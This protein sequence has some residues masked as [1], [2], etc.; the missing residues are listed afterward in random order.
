MSS[1][2]AD[3][4]DGRSSRRR[5]LWGFGA[6]VAL[7]LLLVASVIQSFASTHARR[8]S[9]EVHTHTLEVLLVAEQLRSTVGEAIHGQRGYVFTGQAELLRTYDQAIADASR[10]TRQLREMTVDNP[11][12][13]AR[14][15]AMAGQLSH[16]QSVLASAVQLVRQGNQ[17][18]ALA[19]VRQGLD[20]RAMV[21][22]VA[23]ID[24]MKAEERRLLAARTVASDRAEFAARAADLGIA[25]LALIF[26]LI[27]GWAGLTASRARTRTLE[28]EEKLRRA[29]TTDF[30]TGL[31]NR[32]AFMAALDTEIGR[33]K[34]S[35]Q[36]L[37][38]ALID[39]DNFKKVNDRFGHQGGDDVLRK[40]AEVVRHHMRDSDIVGRIGGEEFGVLMP[41]TDQIQSGI[42]ADRLRDAVARRHFVTG[43]GAL[44]P[45][46]I[47]VGVAHLR[48][49]EGRDNWMGRAD[50]ALYDAK[51][52]GR[53]RTRTAA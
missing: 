3:T 24:L 42:A 22:L 35:G 28:M 12:Q 7:T 2:P 31:L 46:T 43:S 26:L 18:E 16:Y 21:P 39:L 14:I 1:P 27:V 4:E 17:N 53:N 9:E 5:H 38:L 48:A 34:R 19:R 6:L 20:R 40:F 52:A 13:Q 45:M 15:G 51:D 41:D 37:A 30:L 8:A 47:S 44:V 11:A 50:E 49:D 32:R 29:A 36:P 25:A 33:S 23:N 10:L